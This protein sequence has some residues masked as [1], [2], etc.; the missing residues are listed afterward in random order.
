MNTWI[1]TSNFF[2]RAKEGR[3]KFRTSKI[4]SENYLDEFEFY[5]SSY[6]SYNKQKRWNGSMWREHLDQII[7]K[8]WNIDEL[9][10]ATGFTTNYLVASIGWLASQ[11]RIQVEEKLEDTITY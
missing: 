2:L 4:N 6:I 5:S 3:K 11:N 1:S 7:S 8:K 9:K 10:A